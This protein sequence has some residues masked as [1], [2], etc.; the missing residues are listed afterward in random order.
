[1]LDHD[2]LTETNAGVP[3]CLLQLVIDVPQASESVS[4]HWFRDGRGQVGTQ[5]I[6]MVQR[7]LIA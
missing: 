1:L 4:Q 5:P 6:H 3:L 2:Q 7:P